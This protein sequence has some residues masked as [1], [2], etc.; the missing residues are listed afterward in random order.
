VKGQNLS[1]ES[2]CQT[3]GDCKLI[4]SY[5]GTQFDVPFL[6]VKFPGVPWD[7]WPHF[8]LCFGGRRVGLTGGLKN[9]ERTVG[10]RRDDE[11]ADVDGY[12]AVRLWRAYQRWNDKDAL[13][14]LID[15]NEADTRN[16][17]TLAR[18]IHAQ[19]CAE[20]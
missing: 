7:N 19:L 8:D 11:I 17:A 15:Y 6:R 18:I 14:T 20:T 10:I 13:R 12:E 5:Y 9:V 4:V 2:I 3:L 16:L 1:T